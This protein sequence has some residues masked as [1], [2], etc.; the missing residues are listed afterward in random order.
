VT[1][2]NGNATRIRYKTN[3]EHGSSGAPCFDINWR[4]AALHHLG[5]PGYATLHRTD[6]NEGIP[7][8]AILGLLEQRQQRPLLFP[9]RT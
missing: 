1:A 6:Y 7:L 3:T 8:E 5:D 4:L 2:V 9:A